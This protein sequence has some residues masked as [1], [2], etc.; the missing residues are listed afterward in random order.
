MRYL[1]FQRGYSKHTVRNYEADL[2]HFRDYL[3]K[4]GAIDE[5]NGFENLS[6]I[7]FALIRDYLGSLFN[8]YERSTIARKLSAVRS[9]F[10]FW[11]GQV[12]EMEILLP[13]FPLRNWGN[14][15]RNI[16]L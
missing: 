9:F 5:E 6:Q 15:Y 8:V 14:I 11:R 16:C 3:L 2:R 4:K 1:S 13:V 12:L 7:D 10:Y